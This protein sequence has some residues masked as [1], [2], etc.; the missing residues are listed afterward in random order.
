[1]AVLQMSATNS[2]VVGIARHGTAPNLDGLYPCGAVVR[3]DWGPHV[4]GSWRDELALAA[5][6]DASCQ[7]IRPNMV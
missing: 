2:A 6:F 5:Q 4:I 3:P 1:M 7:T